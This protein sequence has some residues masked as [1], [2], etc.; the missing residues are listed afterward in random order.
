MKLKVFLDTNIFIYA[1]EYK[2]SN[3]SLIIGMVNNGILEAI[4]SERVVKEVMHYFRKYYDRK[5]SNEFRNYILQSCS[6]IFNEDI[7]GAIQELKGKIKE[8]DLEQIA[9]VRSM[10]LKY[11]IS[12]DED[13]KNF[14]EYITPK[15]FARLMGVK[16]KTVEY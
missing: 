9:T 8:K 1:F 4:I 5:L 11:L 3:S 13:F 7:S 2:D 15:K 12:Y 14:E 16:P 10:G 6:I